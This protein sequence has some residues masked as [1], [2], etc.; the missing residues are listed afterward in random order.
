MSGCKR[1]YRCSSLFAFT[2]QSN[3]LQTWTFPAAYCRVLS[4]YKATLFSLK[5]L[6]SQ[7]LWRRRE[8]RI[9]AGVSTVPCPIQVQ[10]TFLYQILTYLDVPIYNARFISTQ[11][12]SHRKLLG[13]MTHVYVTTWHTRDMWRWARWRDVST[14]VTTAMATLVTAMVAT[15]QCSVGGGLCN[16]ES[17]SFSSLLTSCG[18]EAAAAAWRRRIKMNF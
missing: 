13:V 8:A 5:S 17:V 11:K 6:I 3:N 18:S 16:I 9:R 10:S 1:V 2:C 12:T 7:S 15:S 14:C 4:V